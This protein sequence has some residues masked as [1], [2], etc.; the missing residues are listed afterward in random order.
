L[1]LAADVSQVGAVESQGYDWAGT[2]E[3]SYKKKI[4][5]P[6]FPWEF[7]SINDAFKANF[8]FS[9][10]ARG[11]VR[12][13][14]YA[15]IFYRLEYEGCAIIEQNSCVNRCKGGGL[16]KGNTSYSVDYTVPP[17]YPDQWPHYVHDR[18]PVTGRI[19][20]ASV[21]LKLGPPEDFVPFNVLSTCVGRSGTLTNTA[22]MNWFCPAGSYVCAPSAMFLEI[23]MPLVHEA[24][25][26]IHTAD[27]GLDG[28]VRIRHTCATAG[29]GEK[30][31]VY[32]NPV[33][34]RAILYKE[35]SAS[36][37]IIGN[38][39]IGS[40]LLFTDTVQKNGARWHLIAPPGAP[41]GWIRSS[42]VSCTRPPPLPPGKPLKLEDIGLGRAH[43]TTAMTTSAR[44]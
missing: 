1:L 21:H 40:R 25:Q 43:P 19:N 41:P 14:A 38:P 18:I 24:T 33:T 10:D 17:V 16:V 6:S 4:R 9:V 23:D 31:F 28:M 2:W 7:T 35:P 30:G 5:G 8:Y 37:P 36:S 29:A 13:E 39:P 15:A 44:G 20:G 27:V 26:P 11:N 42:D 3:S 34:D 12:G 32:I 22:N